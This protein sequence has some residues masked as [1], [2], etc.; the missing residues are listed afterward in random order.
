VVEVLWEQ[1]RA[2]L[3][4]LRDITR[5]KELEKAQRLTQLGKLVAD[6]AHEVNNPLM[7]I[8]GRAQ[9]SLMEDIENEA[10]KKN[11]E[12]IAEE[13]QRAKDII[14]RLLRFSKPSKGELKEADLNKSIEEVVSI[15]EH[16]F[17][18]DNTAI[19]RNYA[20]NLPPISMDEKQIQEVFMNLLNN[21]HDA[22]SGQ[23]VIEIT[24]SREKD[25][26]RIDIKDTGCGISEENMK[27]IFDPFFTTKEKGTGL[28]LSVCYS[29]MKAHGGELKY[30]SKL[31]EGTTATILLPL[32]A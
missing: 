15:V 12:T 27:K 3:V 19:K 9:L 32:E 11:L 17:E 8:S 1:K 2:C 30:K 26:L 7:V 28:G 16:Q 23:G 31:D 22:I 24:T 21:A 18:L 4:S 10:V 25:F 13:C 14:Q 20:Q 29:I 5:R 6:M